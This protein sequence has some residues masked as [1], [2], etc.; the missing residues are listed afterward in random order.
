MELNIEGMTALVVGLYQVGLTAEQILEQVRRAFADNSAVI[1]ITGPP[2]VTVPVTV[3][4][5]TPV[6]APVIPPPPPITQTLP[7]V[8]APPV[9]LL[10]V[11][12]LLQNTIP[13]TAALAFPQIMNAN[14][15]G[16]EAANTAA[17]TAA[18]EAVRELSDA[19]DPNNCDP[20]DTKKL[21][22]AI[23]ELVEE[24]AGEVVSGGLDAVDAL[25]TPGQK[26]ALDNPDNADKKSMLENFFRGNRVHIKV[27]D[28][29]RELFP[30]EF[31][32]RNGGKN[33]G[34]PDY[35][36]LKS[37]LETELTT[38][39]EAAA[40]RRRYGDRCSYAFYDMPTS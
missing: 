5:A 20:D 33:N 14:A 22:E 34:G 7:N 4:G 10:P 27:R 18:A 28:R 2:A 11:G 38:P 32:F 9:S 36:H 13:A 12:E 39:G 6:T 40:H 1:S 8:I 19:Y 24:L 37:K 29:L 16:S 15:D 17:V 25:L 35:L 26:G 31:E 30:G 21:A 3:P 23:R